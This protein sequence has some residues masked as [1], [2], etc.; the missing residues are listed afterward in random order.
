MCS[1]DPS[2][3][4]SGRLVL[5]KQEVPSEWPIGASF[6]QMRL[7]FGYLVSVPGGTLAIRG[8]E[9]RG[10]VTVGVTLDCASRI[11]SVVAGPRGLDGTHELV[12]ATHKRQETDITRE[13]RHLGCPR[14]LQ[15]GL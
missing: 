10:W 8:G 14:N 1:S 7:S 3:P 12:I 2:W 6:I 13:L 9:S 11:Y 5:S 4:E 15:M